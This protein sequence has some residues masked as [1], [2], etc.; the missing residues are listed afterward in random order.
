MYDECEKLIDS[1]VCHMFWSIL[2]WIVQVC[3]LTIEYQVVQYVPSTSISEQF[4]SLPMIHQRHPVVATRIVHALAQEVDSPVAQSDEQGVSGF[5]VPSWPALTALRARV[6][7]AGW[8]KGWLATRSG[9]SRGEAV[10]G[11]RVDQQGSVLCFA[12]FPLDAFPASFVPC[13]SAATPCSLPLTLRSCLCGRPLDAFG[14]HR[15]RAPSQGCWVEEGLPWRVD[16]TL[17]SAVKGDGEPTRGAADRDGVALR[18]A[19]PTQGANEPRTCP[20]RGPWG[21]SSLDLKWEADGQRR[22]GCLAEQAFWRVPLFTEW[23]IASS[24][25]VILAKPSRRSTAGAFT[26]GT[27]G[28]RWFSLILQHER[29]RRRIWWCNCSTLI[30]IGAETA[31]VSFHTLPVGFPLPQSPIILCIRCFVPWFL[32][33][34]FFS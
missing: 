31:I 5:V 20:A 25:E 15:Q 16:T 18:R 12:L 22:R 23:V 2:W 29:I 21:K 30:R 33:T 14:H 27:S 24:F 13:P 19:R 1:D 32:T 9:Q 17:L 34:A 26:S 4:G 10:P 11:P 7:R 8:A 28:S 3:S 6:P